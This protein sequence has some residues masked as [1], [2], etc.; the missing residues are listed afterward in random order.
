MKNYYEYSE[1]DIIKSF[2]ILKLKKNDNLIVTTSLGML[3]F[4]NS[5]NNINEVFLRIIQDHIG[6]NGTLFVPTYSYSFG[7]KKIFNVR[8]TKSCIGDFGN[9]ILKQ[10]NIY[11]SEDP[12]TSIIGLGPK[13]EKILSIDKNTSYGRGCT[14]EKMLNIDLKIIN[15]GLGPNWIPFIHYLDYLNKVPYRHDKIFKG[16]IVD[17]NN[18]KKKITWHYPVRNADVE[19]RANGHLLGKLAEKQK[20]FISTRLGRGRILFA[21]Y[22]KLFKFSK[23]ITSKNKYLTSYYVKNY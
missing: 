1:K 20:I 12:M 2:S 11:R 17:R 19:S 22:S 16:Q 14:F 23:K 21:K 6:L 15:I 5:K 3:G 7:Q 18:I 13:A 9:F 10:K 4:I 8:K